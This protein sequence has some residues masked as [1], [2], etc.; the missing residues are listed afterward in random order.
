MCVH[1]IILLLNVWSAFEVLVLRS[2]GMWQSWS[3]FTFIK[4]KFWLSKLVECECE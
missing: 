4:C 1:G 3:K 2:I